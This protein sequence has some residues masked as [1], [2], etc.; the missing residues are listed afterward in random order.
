M[1]HHHEKKLSAKHPAGTQVADHIIKALTP[2]IQEGKITCADAH[3]LAQAIQVPVHQIGLALDLSDVRIVA[4]QLGL[5]ERPGSVNA[6]TPPPQTPTGLR[7]SL[8]AAVKDNAITCR[9][10]WQLAQTHGVSRRQ[11]GQACNAMEVKIRQC[12]LG[13][14]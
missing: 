13:A 4:C 10:A 2:R 5:F 1:A 8:E 3:D 9:Q 6:D 14:F 7:Q 11:V 12:Q